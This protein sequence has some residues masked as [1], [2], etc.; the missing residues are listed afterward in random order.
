[1][2]KPAIIVFTWDRR[3]SHLAGVIFSETHECVDLGMWIKNEDNVWY[4][5]CAHTKPEVE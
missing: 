4:G 1:M 2:I 5:R 3:R